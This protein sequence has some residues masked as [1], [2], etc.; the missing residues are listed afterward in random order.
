MAGLG[1]LFLLL[2]DQGLGREQ[3]GGDGGRVLQGGAG[4]LHRVDDAGGDQVA[5]L[6]GRGVEALALVE[7]GDLGG[8]DVALQAGVLGDPAQRLDGGA[9]D[10]RDTGGLVAVLAQ[11]V[12]QHLDGVDQGGATTGDDALLD[13]GAGRGDGV[14]Q[15]VL[16]LLELD[17]GG[18]AHADDA[19]AAG[20]LGEALLELLAVPVRVGG[21]DLGLDLG[22]AAGDL[23]GV[24]LAVDDGGVVLGDGHA[25]GGT[26]HVQADLVEL[27]ADLLGDD[28]GTGEGGHVAQHRL[29]AVAEAGGLDGDGVE[30]AADLVDDEGGEG[31]ALDV[32][33]DDQQRLGAT[34]LD[35]LLQQREQVGDGGDLALVD[36][37]VRVVEDGLH[38]LLVG[39]HVGREVALV[40]GHALGEV[41]LQAEG[42]GLLDGDD[43]VLADLVHR[44]GDE[45]ADLL[46]LGGQRGHGG[47]VG[48]GVDRAGG[49]E[50]LVGDGLDRGVDALLQGGRG[51]AGGDVAQTLADQ[52]LGQHGRGGGAVTRDVVG[53]GRHLLDELGAQVLVRVLQLDLAR[54]GDAVV[55]DG[56]GAELLVDDD[57]A[58]LGADRHLDRV[59]KLVDAALEGATGVLVELQGLRHG[60]R[61]L[62][63]VSQTNCAPGARLLDAG[64][65]GTEQKPREFESFG[66]NYFSMIARTSR[67]E[68]TRYSSPL[69]FTSVPPYLL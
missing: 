1:L 38:T 42:V 59:G 23:G 55:G 4:D 68:R 35:D 7:L 51:G 56:G 60:L 61:I 25:A 57:V 30:G 16:L 49:R 53:L 17:L 32:L 14:L 47:D 19:H 58:A 6:A 9:A 37:D 8:D 43:A 46:V 21:L 45:L 39:D 48:L 34:G 15:T 69:Y 22:H 41:E 24:A 52:R 12:L 11:V 3:Q 2:D 13:R 54:D 10:D 5:V 63:R 28:G 29:A 33:G 65:R 26:E 44:L 67:A 64:T 36:Q 18:R 31:L 50:Q 62:R 20:E 66:V 27:E 40:E